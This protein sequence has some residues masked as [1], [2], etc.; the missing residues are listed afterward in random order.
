MNVTVIVLY[1]KRTPL[2]NRS[3][4]GLYVDLDRKR[5]ES[6]VKATFIP[7][8]LKRE[9]M[10]RRHIV[11]AERIATTNGKSY[12]GQEGLAILTIQ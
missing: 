3:L 2:T 12:P 9:H 11:E 5:I 6:Y 7:E 8:T 10:L 4:H 1:S